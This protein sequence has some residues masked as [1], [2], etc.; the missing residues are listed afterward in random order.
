[1]ST[2]SGMTLRCFWHIKIL[3]PYWFH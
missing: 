1:M 3:F 2:V